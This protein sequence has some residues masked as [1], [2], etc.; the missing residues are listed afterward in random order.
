MQ[1]P[2]MRQCRLSLSETVSE[3]LQPLRTG[4]EDGQGHGTAQQ[5]RHLPI[6]EQG[7]IGLRQNRTWSRLG[8][9]GSAASSAR[10]APPFDGRLGSV[11]GRRAAPPLLMARRSDPTIPREWCQWP[12]ASIV[13]RCAA[14][15][16]CVLSCCRAT[17]RSCALTP[18]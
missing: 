1:A 17:L 14:A 9:P 12:Q 6:I 18:S 3:T 15:H 11:K 4:L 7:G 13:P 2:D 8:D 10:S 16:A 5:A